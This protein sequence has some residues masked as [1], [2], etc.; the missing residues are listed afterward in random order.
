MGCVNMQREYGAA[1]AVKR[2]P[3][4]HL[5]LMGLKRHWTKNPLLRGPYLKDTEASVST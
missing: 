3:F 4:G 1:E 5:F 2:C